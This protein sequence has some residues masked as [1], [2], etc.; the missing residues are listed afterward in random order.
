M[1]PESADPAYLWDMLDR[2]RRIQDYLC[3]RTHEDYLAD[4]QL[5][6]AIERCVEVI[7]E[8][9]RRVSESFRNAHPEIPWRPIVAQRN[10]LAHEYADIRPELIYRVAAVH[11]PELIGHLEKLVPQVPPEEEGDD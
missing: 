1:P 11:I 8:A 5:Q 7:G 4:C 10:I 9:A 6:D 2:A 3:G